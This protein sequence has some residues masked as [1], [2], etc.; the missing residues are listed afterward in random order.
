ME[1]DRGYISPYFIS[2]PDRQASELDEPYILLTDKKVTAISD[3]LPVLEK[4][5]KSART[6]CWWQKM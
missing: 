3:I 4:V 5:S 2:Q 6:L 1:F